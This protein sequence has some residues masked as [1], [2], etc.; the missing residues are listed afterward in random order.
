MIVSKYWQVTVSKARNAK[1]RLHFR[2][3][4]GGG[5]GTPF[6]EPFFAIADCISRFWGL[7][8]EFDRL[9]GRAT[10][11]LSSGTVK[12]ERDQVRLLK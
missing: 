7:M 11:Y 10:F 6:A 9:K 4:L 12:V 8:G 2:E 1:M 5:W 3:E